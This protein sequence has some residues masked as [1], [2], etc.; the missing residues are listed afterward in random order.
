MLLT[1]E[2]APLDSNSMDEIAET[3]QELS[4]VCVSIL[5][6]FNGYLSTYAKCWPLL[7]KL[8]APLSVA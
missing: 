6:A 4:V 8:S 1:V 5:N 3:L 7:L 2:M